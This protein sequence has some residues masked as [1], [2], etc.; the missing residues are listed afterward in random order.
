[1]SDQN[2]KKKFLS[3]RREFLR[4]AGLLSS[5]GLLPMI[6]PAEKAIAEPYQRKQ[7]EAALVPGKPVRIRGQVTSEGSPLAKIAVTDGLRITETNNDGTYE[8][9]SDGRRPFVYITIPAGYNIPINPTGT[10]RFFERIKPGNDDIAEISFELEP[11]RVSDDHHHFLL[12]ADPQTQNMYEVER[13]HSETVPDI[14]NLVP[15]FGDKP[16]FGIGCG[17]LM[18]D[19]LDLFP[20]YEKAVYKS[21]IPFFQVLGNHDILFDVRSTEA[22]YEVFYEYFGPAY[23]SFDMGEIH[24]VVLNDIFW[25]GKG[26]VGYI[27]R[28]QLDWLKADLAR[29]EAGRTVVVS[30]HIPVLSMQYRRLGHNNPPTHISVQNR[31]ELYRLLEPYQAHVLSAHTHEHEHVFENGIHE[32]IHGTV[33]GAWWSGPICWDGTPNGYGLY[34]ARGSELRWTYKSTGFDLDHQMRVY[35]KG[36]DPDAPHEIVANVWDWE[37]EWNVVWYEGGDRRGRMSQ[38]LGRDPKSV[39][40]HSGSDKPERRTWVNPQLTNHLFYA[41]VSGAE[42]DIVVE[43]TNRWGDVFTGKI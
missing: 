27:D 38:R 23:Y 25:H 31:E 11:R 3:S 14:A 29:V 2:S 15:Q 19:D 6:L 16:A 20:E 22:S 5:A 40:L 35:K 43:A 37:P 34:E 28:D 18:F 36:S 39:E 30:L 9:Y 7:N 12:L 4:K 33:C 8:L 10:A 26:Y 1:M 42:S 13:F 21:G 41:P 24:Y 17:D 32:H